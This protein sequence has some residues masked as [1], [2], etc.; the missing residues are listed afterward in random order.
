MV[1]TMYESS[2]SYFKHFQKQFRFKIV[3]QKP[4]DITILNNYAVCPHF[5]SEFC[6]I[7]T[8]HFHLLIDS[9]TDFGSTKQKNH[10]L[11]PVFHKFQTLF[12]KFFKTGNEWIRIYKVEV[13]R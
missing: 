1:E 10:L 8:T 4:T 3:D 11:S 2:P 12:F 6:H 7:A 5:E 9:S 13:S